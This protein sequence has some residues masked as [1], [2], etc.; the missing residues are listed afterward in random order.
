MTSNQ[1]QS[2]DD[3]AN[4]ALNDVNK[5]NADVGETLTSLQNIIE[6]NANELDRIR[7]QLK[8]ERESLKGVFENDSELAHAEE[9]VTAVIQQ[10][11]ERKSK[12]QNSPQAN[13]IKT[14][15]TELNDQKKEIEEALNNHLLNLYQMTGTNTFDTS[16]GQQREFRVRASLMGGK[17]VDEAIDV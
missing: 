1:T 3:L 15:I 12:L 4:A 8:T 16:D 11:K 7:E 6:R 14:K 5:S 9:E 17:K 2:G 13:Q 10:V